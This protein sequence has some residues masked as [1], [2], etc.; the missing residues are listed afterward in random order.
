MVAC[1]FY[2]LFNNSDSP[3]IRPNFRNK[4]KR[5]PPY[6]QLTDCMPTETNE[7]TGAS[8]GKNSSQPVQ[9]TR[10]SSRNKH[11]FQD[12]GCEGVS[13]QIRKDRKTISTYVQESSAA[14]DL[15][16][17]QDRMHLFENLILASLIR[18]YLRKNPRHV[19]DLVFE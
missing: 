14:Y 17:G 8:M 4:K 19:I 15:T 11:V 18:D 10:K 13:L 6:L 12:Y 16:I 7:K 2:H 9:Q 5:D 1:A 3:Q